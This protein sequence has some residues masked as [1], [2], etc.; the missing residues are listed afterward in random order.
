MGTAMRTVNLVL[1]GFG[2]VGQAFFRLVQDKAPVCRDVH[3]LDLRF[4]AVLKS[5]GGFHTGHLLKSDD[6]FR[7]SRPWVDGNPAWRPGFRIGEALASAEPGCLVECTP[8]NIRTGEPGLAHMTQAFH[9]G[10][11]VVAASKG[12]LVVAFKKLRRLAAE[13]RAAL[14][15]SG[16]AAAALPALDVGLYSLAGSEVVEIQGVLNGTSNYIL[17]RMG[18]GDSY[19]EALEEA[20]AR[21]I[22]ES[23]PTL[24]V[25]GWDTA[26]KLLLIANA[27]LGL[28]LELADVAVDGITNITAEDIAAVRARGAALKLLGVCERPDPA[29]PWRLSVG[30]RP[31]PASH[32]LHGVSGTEKGIT[33]R[34]DAMGAVTVTGGG[35]DPRGTGAALLKD[36]INTYRAAA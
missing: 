17:T 36:I 28:D 27:V 12:A 20:R 7:E 16:A 31:L 9:A 24:D 23:D 25:G 26:C 29:K 14:R 8:S 34:T 15:F 18:I 10:W 5:G 33:F 1:A 32:P 13:R 35:S 3:G 6:L 19:E 4:R 2:H 22:A 21:G 30:P 11:N